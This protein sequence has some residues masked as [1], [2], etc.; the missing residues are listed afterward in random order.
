MKIFETLY[1]GG[2]VVKIFV[3]QYRVENE[4]SLSE[5]SRRSGVA[6][7]HISQIEAGNS[8][9]TVETMCKL[10]K[11]LNVPICKLLSCD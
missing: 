5:L 8:N 9:P 3:E 7:S 6:K 1:V 2:G 4:L 10:S 11:A